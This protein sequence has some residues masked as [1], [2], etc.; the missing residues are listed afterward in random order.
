[1]SGPGSLRGATLDFM[2]KLGLSVET[3]LEAGLSVTSI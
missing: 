2:E 1:M 3:V